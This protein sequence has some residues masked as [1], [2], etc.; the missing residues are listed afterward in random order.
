MTNFDNIKMRIKMAIM[1][2]PTISVKI[3]RDYCDMLEPCNSM[4]EVPSE[5]Q[6]F[7][8]IVLTEMKEEQEELE[9]SKKELADIVPINDLISSIDKAL[10]DI[11]TGANSDENQI[12]G[13]IAE[14]QNQADKLFD[15][16]DENGK[17]KLKVDTPPKVRKYDWKRELRSELGNLIIALNDDNYRT[18]YAEGENI[19]LYNKYLNQLNSV[20]KKYDLYVPDALKNEAL[21]HG[22]LNSK[23]LSLTQEQLMMC[24]SYLL[25][26]REVSNE[27]IEGYL[28]NRVLVG[29]STLLYNHLY[30]LI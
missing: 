7:V 6:R 22:Y 29:L 19:L 26:K 12:K 23:L 9:E 5:L 4:E 14:Y 2:E 25:Q 27:I 10:D 1:L 8:K 30:N 21:I 3:Q 16:I 28:D 13:Q 20:F 24:L 17:I 11:Q 15:Y 18:T